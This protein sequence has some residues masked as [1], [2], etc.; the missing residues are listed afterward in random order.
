M[1]YDEKK[2]IAIAGKELNTVRIIKKKKGK[3]S[4][5]KPLLSITETI[6]Q[7]FYPQFTYHSILRIAQRL[8]PE[9]VKNV[10]LLV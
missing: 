8:Q 5:N 10:C 2:Y 3:T 1:K 9:R 7:E 4:G 6:K